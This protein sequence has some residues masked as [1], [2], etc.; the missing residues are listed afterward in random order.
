MF[1][2][3]RDFYQAKLRDIDR[4]RAGV[5]GLMKTDNQSVLVDIVQGGVGVEHI[6]EGGE[7]EMELQTDSVGQRVLLSVV[8]EDGT[9]VMEET[10][11]FVEQDDMVKQEQMVEE[12]VD[13]GEMVEQSVVLEGIEGDLVED[14]INMEF[15]TDVSGMHI[16]ENVAAMEFVET[17][18]K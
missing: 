8:G 5:A 16:V 11:A 4:S 18:P 15:V 14:S 17:I 9:V 2:D 7:G 12:F 10:P 3:K 1:R 6:V 13:G